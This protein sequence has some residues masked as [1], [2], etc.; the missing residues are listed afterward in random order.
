MKAGSPSVSADGWVRYCIWE[1]SS[2]IRDLYTARARDEKEEMTCAAQAAE[3]VAPLVMPGDT[4]LD[5]GCGSGYFFH[6][7]RRRSIAAEYYG[8]DAAPTLIAI[9]RRELAAFGL[10]PE[11]LGVRRIEDIDGAVDHVICLNVL[12]NID[13]YHRPLERLL[14]MARKSLI[15]RESAGA[16][17]CYSY[18][19]D[20]YLDPGVDLNVHVNRYDAAELIGFMEAYGFTVDR[21]ADRHSGDAPEMVIGHPHWWTFFRAVRVPAAA[22]SSHADE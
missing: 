11:R 15:L 18:V 7:L 12:S 10:P 22:R 20:V 2:T 17:A 4:L 14:K 13:N 6:S 1:H 16:G 21:I 3:L 5:A 9:G 8:I 19:R